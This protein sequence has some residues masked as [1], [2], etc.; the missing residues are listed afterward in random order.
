M[1][2]S[3]RGVHSSSLSRAG[4][5]VTSLTNPFACLVLLTGPWA[6]S[7]AVTDTGLVAPVMA[8]E[9]HG[10]L[11]ACLQIVYSTFLKK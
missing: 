8:L 3:E 1:V 6:S 4:C 2:P 10:L 5:P 7:I 9:K 11:A